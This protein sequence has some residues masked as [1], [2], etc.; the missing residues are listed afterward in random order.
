MS[1]EVYVRDGESIE[2][3][4]RRFRTVARASG[5]L[6]GRYV[7]ITDRI[8]QVPQHFVGSLPFVPCTFP[9]TNSR[10]T[11]ANSSASLRL[12]VM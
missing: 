10:R 6:T 3:A 8:R 2:N 9:S 11:S 12:C 1:R 5:A 7:R 4:I